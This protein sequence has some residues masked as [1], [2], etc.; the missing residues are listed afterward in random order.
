VVIYA[1]LA[2]FQ[3]KRVWVVGFVS[4][5]ANG[6]TPRIE[7]VAVTTSDCTLVYVGRQAKS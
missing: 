1:E 3:G 7:L 2:Q 4:T 6:G 5:P